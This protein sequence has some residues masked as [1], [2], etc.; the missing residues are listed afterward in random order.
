[1]TETIA[2]LVPG[3]TDQEFAS[4]FRQRFQETIKPV[5]ELLD[6]ATQAGFVINFSIGLNSLG[7]QAVR[8]ILIIKHF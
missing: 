5:I 7:R 2:K 8:E 3:P 4:T 6:E 1:M